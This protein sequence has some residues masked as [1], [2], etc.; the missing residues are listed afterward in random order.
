MKNVL[1]A[2]PF[3]IV[4]GYAINILVNKWESFS[5]LKLFGFSF[6]IILLTYFSLMLMTGYYIDFKDGLRAKRIK[7]R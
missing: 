6:G 5:E 1:K 7:N 2:I 3:L 4:L